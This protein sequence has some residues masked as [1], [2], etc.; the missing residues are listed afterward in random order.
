MAVHHFGNI[1]FYAA[2]AVR[3]L[4]FHLKAIPPGILH[5]HHEDESKAQRLLFLPSLTSNSCM[6]EGPTFP[7]ATPNLEDALCR[8]LSYFSLQVSLPGLPCLGQA[9]LGF[10]LKG[11]WRCKKGKYSIARFSM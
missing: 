11:M 10:R 4:A 3:P 1:S 2:G 5:P 9:S 8:L 7:K 6:T